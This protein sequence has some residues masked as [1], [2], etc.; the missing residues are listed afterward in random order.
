MILN[1][2]LIITALAVL[3]LKLVTHETFVSVE[4]T[5]INKD[6]DDEPEISEQKKIENSLLYKH[7]PDDCEKTE[8]SIISNCS[9]CTFKTAHKACAENLR[10]LDG[11]YCP[12]LSQ[13]DDHNPYSVSM[14]I[15]E[16]LDDNV[17]FA[18]AKKL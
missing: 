4:V 5:N 8:G 12:M 17:R 7:K 2:L 16:K 13:C 18:Q 15:P 10:V 9:G 11:D 3:I 1:V 6:C 14:K